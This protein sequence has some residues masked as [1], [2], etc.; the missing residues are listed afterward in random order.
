[1]INLVLFGP[2]GSGKG[3]QAE[4]LEEAFDLFHISTGDLLRTE[5]KNE[6][7][8]GKKAKSYVEEGKLLP[9]E[10][11]VDMMDHTIQNHQDKEGFIFDGF[12]RTIAQAEALDQLLKKH[13]E[14]VTEVLQLKVSEKELI[15]RLLKRGETSGREDDQDEE[16]I[17]KRIKEYEEKT[18]PVADYYK[19]DGKLVTV[20]GEG[21]V[22]E[23]FERLKGEIDKA[24]V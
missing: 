16:T 5:I 7:P 2:P 8:L 23:I 10:L 11:I 13:Q 6:T 14:T 22:D 9:D 4:K 1:M 21:T 15:S 17:K 12:P 18:A 20:D 24:S 19:K 3:T